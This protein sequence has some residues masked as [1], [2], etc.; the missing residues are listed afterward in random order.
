METPPSY[1]PPKKSNTGLIIGLVL[2]GIG[3]CCVGGIALVLFGGLQFF[4]NVAPMAECMMNYSAVQKGMDEYAQANN[5]KLPPAATWQNDLKPYVEK[6]LAKLKKEA[7]PFKVMDVNGDWGCTTG[8]TKT[9]MAY[10]TEIAGKTLED[11]RAKA[12]VT[13]FE[14]PQIGRNQALKFEE[15][16]RSSS[17]KL[18]GNPRGWIKIV[19]GRVHMDGRDTDM[20]F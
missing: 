7:G 4:K 11:V 13:V 18:M 8:E 14:T 19:G 3:I 17:P 2:G 6:S 10:N 9:G 12:L 5:G 16:P 15:L 1:A 20:K